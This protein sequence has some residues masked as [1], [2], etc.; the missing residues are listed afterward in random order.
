MMFLLPEQN[1]SCVNWAFHNTC[2][3]YAQYKWSVLIWSGDTYNTNQCDAIGCTQHFVAKPIFFLTT[4]HYGPTTYH[5]LIPWHSSLLPVH[6]LYT[7]PK[8]VCGWVWF[9]NTNKLKFVSLVLLWLYHC[10]ATL[11]LL[12]WVCVLNTNTK[13]Y[14]FCQCAWWTMNLSLG[15]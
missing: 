9:A 3:M 10:M 7:H 6:T 1:Q 8:Q 11:N 2:I 14:C 4:Q 13:V 15:N 12:F 5:S